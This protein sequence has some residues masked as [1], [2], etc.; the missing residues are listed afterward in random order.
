VSR[1]L[2]PVQGKLLGLL[3]TRGR[4]TIAE[5]TSSLGLTERRARVVV[6]SL[7]E[8]RLVSLTTERIAT[9]PTGRPV[10]GTIVWTP[11]ALFHR[12]ADR[13]TA[14]LGA[15]ARAK[16]ARAVLE[17]EARLAA[18]ANRRWC[19]C[20]GQQITRT[21]RARFEASANSSPSAR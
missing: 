3:A 21:D 4:L 17:H 6:T 11:I 2:G 14:A 19:P 18:W 20:C 10:H 8:R 1:G 9:Q 7:S 16:T 13:F 12:D 5:I 15:E